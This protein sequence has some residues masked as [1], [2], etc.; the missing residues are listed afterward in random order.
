MLE[1]RPSSQKINKFYVSKVRLWNSDDVTLPHFD[2]L[3]HCELG[4]WAIFKVNF[5]PKITLVNLDLC[6]SLQETNDNSEVFFAL[7]LQVIPE[8]YY[9]QATS[10][11]RLR[12]RYEKQTLASE[13]QQVNKKI[14]VQYAF[15]NDPSEQQQLFAFYYNRVATM[16]RITQIREMLPDKLGSKLLLRVRESW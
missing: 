7:E 15:G 4:K 10:D 2:E 16:P 3:T 1:S 9:N 11:Y 12:F 8:E 6:S 13:G 14:L 5:Y